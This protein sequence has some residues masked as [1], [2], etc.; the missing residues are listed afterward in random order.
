MNQVLY[1]QITAVQKKKVYHCIKGF[2]KQNANI[3]LSKILHSRYH[4]Y[5]A[6]H[7]QELSII[8]LC[9]R[10]FTCH[11]KWSPVGRWSQR[12]LQFIVFPS[13]TGIGCLIARKNRFGSSFLWQATIQQENIYKT[14]VLQLPSTC[15]MQ[16]L[17]HF[18]TPCLK[19]L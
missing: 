18:S 17:Q 8:L 4:S 5:R 7:F 3:W 15:F 11:I 14:L 10:Y 13:A 6:D 16:I 2:G 9:V 1:N 12:Q 19:G